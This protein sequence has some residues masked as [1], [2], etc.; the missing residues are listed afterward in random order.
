[1]AK[2]NDADRV[3]QPRSYDDT[4]LEA[5]LVTCATCGRRYYMTKV[6]ARC[7]ACRVVEAG[8]RRADDAAREGVAIAECAQSIARR[9]Q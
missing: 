9:A 6:E 7:A 5:V 3:D 2:D 1:M 8:R 4:Q